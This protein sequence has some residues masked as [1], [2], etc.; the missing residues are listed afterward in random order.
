MDSGIH[1]LFAC[2]ML[3]VWSLL[4]TPLPASVLRELLLAGMVWAL[5]A[6]QPSRSGFSTL[7]SSLDL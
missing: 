5:G 7:A 3:W 2:L 1:Q 6:E 4:R